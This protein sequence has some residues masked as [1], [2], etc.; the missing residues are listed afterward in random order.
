MYRNKNRS[1]TTVLS[2]VLRLASYI[3]LLKAGRELSMNFSNAK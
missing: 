2:D 1:I 3:K